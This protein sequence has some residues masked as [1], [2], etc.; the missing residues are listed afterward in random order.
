MAS[1]GY[2]SLRSAIFQVGPTFKRITGLGKGDAIKI[3][4]TNADRSV[5]EGV[6]GDATFIIGVSNVRSVELMLVPSSDDITLLMQL[7]DLEI[8][9]P[10]RYEFGVTNVQGFWCIEKDCDIVVS[11][12]G[13]PIPVT[14]PAWLANRKIGAQGKKLVL[15]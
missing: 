15:P 14:G 4:Q 3:I 2:I 8:P 5:V 1:A 13:N 11:D 9:F 12:S 7:R 10:F 6:L